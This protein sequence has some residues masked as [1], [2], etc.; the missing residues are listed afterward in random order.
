MADYQLEFSGQQINNAIKYQS[1][2]NY[3]LNPTFNINQREETSYTNTDTAAGVYSVDRWR[4]STSSSATQDGITLK[5]AFS[6]IIEQVIENYSDFQGLKVTATI[7]WSAFSGTGSL[8]VYDGVGTSTIALDS[9]KSIATITHTVSDSATTLIF[10]IIATSITPTYCKL[11][12]GENS[13]QY[14]PRPYS[15][16]LWLCQRYYTKINLDG[17][18]GNYG[19]ALAIQPLLILPNTLRTT[20]TIIPIDYPLIYGQDTNGNFVKY[21]TNRWQFKK[22]LNNSICLLLATGGNETTLNFRQNN[23]YCLKNGS[24]ALDAEIK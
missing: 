11:E 1:N 18:T 6:G 14:I 8:V 9:G 20:P 24:V 3:L 13:T 23:F 7:K 12:I 10:R 22:T 21:K 19:T 16:E 5:W 2:Y 15:E 4:L 17:Q